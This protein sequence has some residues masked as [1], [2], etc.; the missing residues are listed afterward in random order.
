MKQRPQAPSEPALPAD[1]TFSEEDLRRDAA[2]IESLYLRNKRVIEM[3]AAES[4][5]KAYFFWQPVPQFACDA[6]KQVFPHRYSRRADAVLGI[7]YE[8]VASGALTPRSAVESAGLVDLS[9][10]LLHYDRPPFVDAHH[11]TPA[12]CRMIAGQIA[13]RIELP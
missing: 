2:W 12:V 6:S 11:Y 7:V 5:V 3:V 13:D 1:T 4:G 8:D 9:Q 10:L